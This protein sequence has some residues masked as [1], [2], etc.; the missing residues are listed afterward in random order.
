M[1][2]NRIKVAGYAQKVTYDGNIEYRN[3]SDSLVGNQ[4]T[5]DG[6]TTLFTA[7][8]FRITTNLD[9]KISKMFNTN[10]FGNFVS[11]EDLRLTNEE[12]VILL[13]NNSRINLNFDKSD[14]EN[15]AY[16]GSLRE[17]IRVSLESIIINWPAALF[18]SPIN[19]FNPFYNGPTYQNY[20]LNTLNGTST[21]LINSSRF[22]NKFNVNYSQTGEILNTFSDSNDLRNM[23]VNYNSYNVKTNIGEYPIIGFTG[24]SD[25]NSNVYIEVSGFPFSNS[26]TTA[27]TTTYHIKPNNLKVESFFNN[28][29]VFESN[30]LNRL[31]TPKY[32]S[33]YKY[34]LETEQ[35]NIIDSEMTITWPVSDGYNI[36]FDSE[37]YVEFVNNLLTIADNNDAVNTNLMSRFFVSESIH[38]F[39]TVDQKVG[40]TLRIYGR[41]FDEIKR[42]IDGLSYAHTVTYDRIKNTPDSV[43]KNLAKVM[44]WDLISSISNIDLLSNYVNTTQSTFEGH[45]RGL[46][47]IEAEV[48]LWRRI[49]LNTPWL[50]KSK[51]TRKAIEFLFKFIGSPDGLVDF[52]EFIYVAKNS[53]D[54]E[55]FKEILEANGDDTDITELNIDSEGFPKVLSDTNEMYFQKAGLWYRETSGPNSNVDILTGNNPHI[56]PYD[57]GQ[58]YINQF[59]CLIPDFEPVT[60]IE[61][62]ITT[63]S[64]NL[65]SNYDYGTFDTIFENDIVVR[66]NTDIDFETILLDQVKDCLSNLQIVPDLSG[67]SATTAWNITASLNGV[68][69]YSGQ[70]GTN[71]IIEG[72]LVVSGDTL[73]SQYVTQV[74]NIYNA[75]NTYGVLSLVSGATEMIIVEKIPKCEE[76]NYYYG[77]KVI[78][79]LCLNTNYDCIGGD[80]GVDSLIVSEIDPRTY[81]VYFQNV[82]ESIV[83]SSACCTNLGFE[84]SATTRGFYCYDFPDMLPNNANIYAYF[85]TTS[86]LPT[87]GES[88]YSALQAWFSD[89]IIQYP[90][91]SG[92]LYTIP[93]S[94]E[95]WL[96]NATRPWTGDVSL[97]TTTGIWPSITNLPPSGGSETEVVVLSFIDES[98]PSYHSTTVAQGFGGSSIQP[99]ATFKDDYGLFMNTY[100]NYT[101]FKCLLYPIV[102]NVAGREG[103]LVLQILAA[104]EGRLVPSG[105]LPSTNVDVSLVTVQNPYINAPYP[106]TSPVGTMLPLKDFGFQGR[107]DKESPASAVFTSQTFVDDL[108]DFISNG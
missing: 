15:Y 62:I 80:C 17:F 6:G 35:G 59:S 84:F 4:F 89:L 11:L 54:I 20:S 26:A 57:G 100:P 104:L 33:N 65:F 25:V 101:Y 16:F 10:M 77:K 56:G 41:E 24:T 55:L 14:L 29:N 79:E 51:G 82:L 46:S 83:P 86:M 68:N 3:F 72:G 70:F 78:I 7:A 63:G 103:A 52:N 61:E 42:F 92:N 36:D 43:V 2:D 1:A 38:D 75:L 91:Y 50:W 60:L 34:S 28:L 39:D 81:Q 106:S 98:N 19:E 40:N 27:S 74:T 87:D 31:T 18:V 93:L 90:S 9:P 13:E 64:T 44:G 96:R 66:V 22:V 21:F 48:E 47:P 30:L 71:V 49:I 45:E 108:N 53:L 107:Y 67:C 69:F 85:D 102:E 12:A 97:L 23:A 76:K 88:I 94:D 95:N 105:Q 5:S 58:E 8:N 32:S 99:T 73:H 37:R